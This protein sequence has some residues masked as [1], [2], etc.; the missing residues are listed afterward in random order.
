MMSD[1]PIRHAIAFV[2]LLAGASCCSEP[3]VTVS[4]L[5]SVQTA[6]D[7]AFA[8]VERLSSSDREQ[9]RQI[10]DASVVKGGLVVHIGCGDGKLTAALHANDSYLV[11]GLDADAKNIE[12]AR[13]HIR[14]L[15]IEG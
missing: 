12:E 4:D 10:L 6:I 2:F 5:L 14:S 1:L 11:H 15:G 3:P 9:A 8:G 13:E 7:G